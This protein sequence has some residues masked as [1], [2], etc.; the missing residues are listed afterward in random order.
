MAVKIDQE[1][2]DRALLLSQ[3]SAALGSNWNVWDRGGN[4]GLEIQK[5]HGRAVCY[6]HRIANV[7]TATRKI[8]CYLASSVAE[9]ASLLANDTNDWEIG[10][11]EPF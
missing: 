9:L 2:T 10:I 4:Y 6:W 11:V 5:K 1:A 3:L 8:S 7:D